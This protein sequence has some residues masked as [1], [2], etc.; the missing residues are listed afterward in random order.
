M[1]VKSSLMKPSSLSNC[2][3]D[4]DF[5]LFSNNKHESATN[6][7][8]NEDSSA[9]NYSSLS[10]SS[11]SSIDQEPLEEHQPQVTL[12]NCS[13]SYF[14]GYLSKKCY[15]KFKCDICAN[16]TTNPDDNSFKQEEF[17]IFCRNYDSLTSNLFLKRP[18]SNF[19]AFVSNAQQIIKRTI[20]KMP[21]KKKIR[22]FLCNKIKDDNRMFCEF[23]EA[24]TDHYTFI[25]EHLIN[26]KLLRDFNWKSKN[27]KN[28]RAE[29]TKHK[30]NILRNN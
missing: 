16:I 23:P 9:S 29:K 25:I 6:D 22:K 4:D 20:E 1:N 24:C 3:P 8:M 27:L 10:L 2:E 7:L 28:K 14:A 21:Q 17:L 11:L 18:T 30:L 15:D 26:C 12:E 5:H 13:N 19:T